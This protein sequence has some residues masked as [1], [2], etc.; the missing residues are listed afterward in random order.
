MGQ[1]IKIQ[2][3]AKSDQTC[4]FT[5]DQPVYAES[6]VFFANKK[7]AEASPLA[8]KIFDIENIAGVMISDNVVTVTKTGPQGW[9]DIAKEIGSVIRSHLETGAPAVS[10]AVKTD[11]LPDEEIRQKVQEVLNTE[12]NPA[13]ASHGGV[14]ELIDVKNNTVYIRMGG[15][16]QGCGMASVTLRQGVE[17]M[18]REKVPSLG[19]ILDTTDHAAG[20]NP[21]Y[22]PSK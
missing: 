8:S 17:T 4:E 2:A 11:L 18:L 9:R 3:E 21:Y 5:V 1:E 6:S 10:D 7:G 13:V 15:G 12:V 16:C 20:R 14:I 19:E 22:S